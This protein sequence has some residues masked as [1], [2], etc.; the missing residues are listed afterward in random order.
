MFRPQKSPP[1]IRLPRIAQ[2][3][4]YEML[5]KITEQAHES[6]G[7][8]VELPFNPERQQFG[9]IIA[10]CFEPEYSEPT[11]SLTTGDGNRVTTIFRMQQSDVTLI[12]TVI[13]SQCLGTDV[14]EAISNRAKTTGTELNL[15]T[16]IPSPNDTGSMAFPYMMATLHGMPPSSAAA[17]APPAAQETGPAALEG[18]LQTV[19]YPNLLQSISMS[20][21]TGRL[22][23]KSSKGGGEF[24][25]EEGAPV[26]AIAADAQGDLA[27]LESLTWEDGKFRFFERERTVERNVKK[28]LDSLLMEGIGLLDQLKYLQNSGVKMETYLFRKVPNLTEKDFEQRVAQFVPLDMNLQKQ[29]YQSV[30]NISTLFELLRRRPLV[31]TEWV[32]ILFNLIHADLLAFSDKPPAGVRMGLMEVQSLDRSQIQGVMSKLVRPET[33]LYTYPMFLFF[34]EQEFHRFE[35]LNVPFSVVIFDMRLRDAMGLQPLSGQLLNEAVRRLITVRRNLDIIAHFETFD[36]AAILPH[37]TTD[38]AAFFA[39]RVIELIMQTPLAPHIHPAHIYL[40]F[41]VAGVPEDCDD[42]AFLIA[43]AKEARTRAASSTMP[44]CLFKNIH[45]AQSPDAQ[46]HR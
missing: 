27:I 21:M 33:G 31:K 44:V 12:Q 24:Y 22:A 2:L 37:T 18:D 9:Y 25:F 34:L 40:S 19:P 17:S 13:E 1:P 29:F 11:W 8:T 15:K 6:R 43:A 30:D 35:R 41:G 42:P 38:S 46:G 20:K 36:F 7:R 28:R 23:V 39:Q 45:S 5:I 26:Y 32:P 4:T 14:G 16:G 10:V 3:P